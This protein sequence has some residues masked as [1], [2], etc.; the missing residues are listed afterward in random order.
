M[1]KTVS[2]RWIYLSCLRVRRNERFR[3][4]RNRLSPSRTT[5]SGNS[6]SRGGWSLKLWKKLEILLAIWG[7]SLETYMWLM[8]FRFA[9]V[10]SGIIEIWLPCRDLKIVITTRI[11]YFTLL[12]I[13]STTSA[14]S[15]RRVEH[16]AV[17]CS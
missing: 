7:V 17:C 2:I 15:T 1:P 5:I 16:T 8:D 10:P 6:R 11:L 4:R 3:V 13:S 14:L 12:T 9:K